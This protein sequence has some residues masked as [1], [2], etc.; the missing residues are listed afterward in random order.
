MLKICSNSYFLLY[1][2]SYF[3]FLIWADNLRRIIYISI[4]EINIINSREG[5]KKDLYKKFQINPETLTTILIENAPLSESSCKVI[6]LPRSF[7]AQLAGAQNLSFLNKK[8]AAAYFSV[9]TSGARYLNATTSKTSN[10][11]GLHHFFDFSLHCLACFGSCHL[12][13]SNNVFE[14]QVV[15]HYETGWHQVVV[16]DVFD[17]GLHSA[18]SIKLFGTHLLGNLSGIT[19][20]TNNESV[21]KLFV[22]KYS[23]KKFINTFLPS[24]DCLTMT[25]FLPACLPH[26]RMTTLPF[27]IL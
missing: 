23:W 5:G 22:L 18:F 14:L 10:L 27:F 20:N 21:A 16:V 24:S 8:S 9:P 4:F 11:P 25:A 3:N 19:F 12:L 26:V 15:F 1:T 2:F 17:E 13:V 7:C 6:S